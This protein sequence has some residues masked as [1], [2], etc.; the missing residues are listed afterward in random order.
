MDRVTDSLSVKVLAAIGRDHAI[1][2]GRTASLGT[3]SLPAIKAF[4]QGAQRM[5]HSQWDSATIAF[6]EAVA[7]DSTFGIAYL[8]LAQSIGWVRGAGDAEA[9][10]LQARAG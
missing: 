2:S 1:G 9:V 6:R 10:T 4:L 8:Q 5:R 7:I 3:G